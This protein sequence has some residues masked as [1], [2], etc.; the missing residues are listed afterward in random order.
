MVLKFMKLKV[1]GTKILSW[2]C[3]KCG[4]EM[5]T[6]PYRVQ[7][8]KNDNKE[9]YRSYHNIKRWDLCRTCFGK[10]FNYLERKKY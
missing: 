10:I 5:D 1:N 9:S 8:S 3:D 2:K 4:V 6:P 7:Y